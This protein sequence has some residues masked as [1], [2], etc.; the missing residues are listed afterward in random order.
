MNILI[1]NDDG[2]TA[3]GI[4]A[5]A[6]ALSTKANVFVAA[7]HSQMSANSHAITL[8]K[9]IFAKKVDFPHA[10]DALEVKGTPADC[11]KVGVQIFEEEGHKIDMVFA[12]INMGSNLGND[13]LYSGTVG[14]AMEGALFGKP[15][16]AV[17]V[18]NHTATHFEGACSLAV[19]TID[20][21]YSKISASTV[22]NI[23]V[24]DIPKEEIKGV[25]F[26]KLGTRYYDDRFHLVGEK[27]GF[28]EYKLSGEPADFTGGGM[29]YDVAAIANNYA[30]ITPLQFD[31]TNH[32]MMDQVAKWELKI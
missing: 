31:F 13:T 29:E 12:G 15:S 26:A 4:I 14:A 20:L 7:P 17:S 24:P 23:N 27:D 16:V 25:K 1:A 5:L 32:K 8:G 18:D 6:E 28:T 19:Q 21:V 11:V 3:K 30:T 10:K 22:I 9:N 2:I